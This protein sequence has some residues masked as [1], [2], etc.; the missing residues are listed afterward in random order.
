MSKQVPFHTDPSR[1]KKRAEFASPTPRKKRLSPILLI[2]LAAI[3][4]LGAYLAFGGSGDHP[5]SASVVNTGQNAS[6]SA[7]GIGDIKIPLADLVGGKAKFFDYALS[8]KT[9]VRFFALKS[10]DGT[11]RAAMDACEVCFHAKKGYHQEGD[12]MV[13]NNCGKHFPTALVGEVNGGCHPIGLQ[14]AV[15]GDQL[16][17]KAS[18]LES[19]GEYFQ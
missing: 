6:Q 15:E 13:C 16:V 1:E 5:R 18:E 7:A 10:A 3:V 14:R 4:G 19:R 17:I 12:D 2:A 9:P 8:N 11:Y